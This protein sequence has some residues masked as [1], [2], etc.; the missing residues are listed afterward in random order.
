M[1]AD[2]EEALQRAKDMGCSTLSLSNPIETMEPLLQPMEHVW[3]ACRTGVYMAKKKPGQLKLTPGNR[4]K[5]NGLFLLTSERLLHLGGGMLTHE[6]LHQV[7]I[8]QITGMHIRWGFSTGL[9]VETPTLDMEISFPEKTA[10]AVMQAIENLRRDLLEREAA[11]QSPALA[12]PT[13]EQAADLERLYVLLERGIL[14]PEE[15]NEKRNRIL[16][17]N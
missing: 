4:I 5:I 11:G 16:G 17:G 9:V 13:A 10:K 6:E 1:R 8:G 12:T 3:L 14:T 7:A 15:Y 2:M